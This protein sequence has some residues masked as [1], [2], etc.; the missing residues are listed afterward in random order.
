M[1]L[2]W[3]VET[4]NAVVE[5]LLKM[6]ITGPDQPMQVP[7]FWKIKESFS[8]SYY[9]MMILIFAQI[10]K[11]RDISVGSF[12]CEFQIFNYFFTHD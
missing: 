3:V 9:K 8:N 1:K 2:H 7:S 5:L 4:G 6:C 11:A 10:F 12:C